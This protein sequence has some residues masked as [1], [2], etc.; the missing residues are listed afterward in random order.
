MTVP[1]KYCDFSTPYTFIKV[2]R[3]FEDSRYGELT[4]EFYGEVFGEF[5]MENIIY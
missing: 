1:N 4:L 2:L 3:F 5:F